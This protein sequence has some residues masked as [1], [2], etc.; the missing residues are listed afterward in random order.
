MR[1]IK[2]RAGYIIISGIITMVWAYKNAWEI[3]EILAGPLEEAYQVGSVAREGTMEEKKLKFILT[4][5]TEAFMAA[6]EISI[7]I[8]IYMII[9]IILYQIW[10]FIKPGLY[11][12]E[13]KIWKI[14]YGTYCILSIINIIIT[15]WI[16]LPATCKFFLSFEMSDWNGAEGIKNGIEINLE[17]KIYTYVCLVERTIF[18]C[19][20]ILQVPTITILYI[21]SGWT[22]SMRSI[23]RERKGEEMYQYQPQEAQSTK[24][25]KWEWRKTKGKAQ[26]SKKRGMEE[27]QEKIITR[28]RRGR[29]M[30]YVVG[31]IISGIIA[32]PDIISQVI[33]ATPI[34]ILYEI[35]IYIVCIKLVWFSYKM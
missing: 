26:Q 14:R 10:L 17:A 30:C 34:I 11:E 24:E 13:K 21:R 2:I 18:W 16:I 6:T 19:Q 5:I 32:P 7:C 25:G 12:Y 35:T 23:K 29:G 15:Y 8:T 4:E 3:I 28:Q 33:I 1:E 27:S 31:I 22:K 20:I 9:P